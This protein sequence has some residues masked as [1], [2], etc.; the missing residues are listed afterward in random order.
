MAAKLV[1]TQFSET[2]QYWSREL[3]KVKTRQHLIE[4]CDAFSDFTKDALRAAEQM[5]DAEFLTE[6]LP[7]FHFEKM[8]N[9]N[10]CAGKDWNKKYGRILFPEKLTFVAL[11]CMKANIPFGMAYKLIMDKGAMKCSV[12][13]HEESWKAP[14]DEEGVKIIT[15]TK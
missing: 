13:Y 9:G 10:G 15:I 7:G 6:F 5:G 1:I 2:H 4:V 11:Y 3:A 8:N 14:D 12:P